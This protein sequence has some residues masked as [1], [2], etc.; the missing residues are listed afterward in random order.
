[1]Q[2]EITPAREEGNGGGWIEQR[3]KVNGDVVATNS[4]SDPTRSSGAGMAL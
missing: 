3:E 2:W 1:M 4:S